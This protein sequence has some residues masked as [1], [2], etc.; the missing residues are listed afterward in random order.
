MRRLHEVALD[1]AGGG[2]EVVGGERGAHVGGVTPR[3]AILSGSSQMRMANVWPPRICALAT[4]SIVCSLRLHHARQ[5]VGDLRGGQ[6]LA[7]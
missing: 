6:H 1:L 5:V 4:P 2:G 7:S 3:A